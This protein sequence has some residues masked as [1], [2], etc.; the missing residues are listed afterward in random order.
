MVAKRPPVA[1][2]HQGAQGGNDSA[3]SQPVSRA[4]PSAS[5]GI[6]ARPIRRR[7][8]AS[9]SRAKKQVMNHRCAAGQPYSQKP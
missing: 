9:P 1:P 4:E 8:K 3:S 5:T 2:I 7:L 6:A